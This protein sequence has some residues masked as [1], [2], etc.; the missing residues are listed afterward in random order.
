MIDAGTGETNHEMNRSMHAL[1]KQGIE[2]NKLMRQLTARSTQDT[3]SMAVIAI[4][5]A[6]FLPATFVAVRFSSRLFL[7]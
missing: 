4:I 6:I 2:D 1:S 7:D 3:R 5:S